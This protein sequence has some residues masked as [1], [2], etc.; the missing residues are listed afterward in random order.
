MNSINTHV[1][2]IWRFLRIH[3]PVF[4][5][6]LAV[7][8]L[9]FGRLTT[10]EFWSPLDYEILLDAHQLAPNPW[11]MFRHIGAWFSQPLLQ[12]AF[13]LEFRTFGL[14]YSGYIAVNLVLHALNAFIIYMLVN[15]LFYRERLAA[16]AA[17]LFALGVGSYGR[18]LQT[19]AGQESLLLALF[20]LLVLY[21]FIRND[22]RHAGRLRSPLFWAGLAIYSLTGLTKASTLSLLACLVAYKA[23]FFQR[24]ERR[25]IFSNDLLV[26]LA[27]GLVFQFGQ[28]RWGFRTP[29]VLTEVDGPLVYTYLSAVN[30]F[31]Y[32]NLMVFPLQESSLL[33]EA[34]DV[35]QTVYAARVVIRTLL[36]LGILSFSF[37]GIVFG[38]RPLRFFI[39][40]TYLTLIPFSAQAPGASWL[41]LTHLYLASLGFCVVLAAGAIGC[42]NLLI[43][44]RRRRF[45]PFVV[46]LLFVVTALSLNY[47]LDARNREAA[48]DPELQAIRQET[49]ERMQERPVRLQEAR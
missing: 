20:H 25:P 4:V 16:L 9:A 23:F 22:F 12:L 35:V 11:A 47:R 49:V 26:F 13:L 34:G 36:V 33:R 39:A 43:D 7:V 1:R 6:L 17:V 40:W 38:S 14:D 45:V 41:N 15:M 2:L 8:F 29:T 5:L 46:P 37:F 32:L 31:R 28:S 42:A 18:S 21:L 3:G 44:H 10:G 24:R 48:L 19:V 30:V 27:V